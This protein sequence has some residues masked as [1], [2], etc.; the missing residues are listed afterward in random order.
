[1][2]RQ[3]VVLFGRKQSDAAVLRRLDA[4]RQGT[5]A[6]GVKIFKAGSTPPLRFGSDELVRFP[7]AF[8]ADVGDT[9]SKLARLKSD[10]SRDMDVFGKNPRRLLDRYFNFIEARL[11]A[12]GATL[13]RLLQP[14]GGLFC[15]DDWAYS[16]LRP[17]PNAAVFDAA[18]GGA[19]LP[20]MHHDLVFWTG[21]TVLA[22]RVRGGGTTSS[23]DAEACDRL[24][25]LGVRIVAIPASNLASGID[26]FPESEFPPQFRSFWQDA[27]YPCSP[28]RPQGL[29]R[30]LS[31]D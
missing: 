16:A 17:L 27:P 5:D 2:S 10:V 9:E 22:V 1:M 18:E 21:R 26:C 14:L 12:E 23:R 6:A 11:G 29:P 4:W 20:V 24:M 30:S 15:V 13:E 31:L 8:L 19:P 25:E 28:F 7:P 3:F